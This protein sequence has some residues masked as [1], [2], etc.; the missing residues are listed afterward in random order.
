MAL[1]RA[2]IRRFKAADDHGNELTILEIKPTNFRRTVNGNLIDLSPPYTIFELIDG[3]PVN[4]RKDGTYEV[5]RT[6]QGLR[7]IG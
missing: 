2:E 4:R 6:G 3:E 1:G 7:E 5:V